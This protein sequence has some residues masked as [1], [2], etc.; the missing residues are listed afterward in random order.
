MSKSEWRLLIQHLRYVRDTAP[1]VY[2]RYVYDRT[3]M[4]TIV[5]YPDRMRQSTDA[6][7]ARGGTPSEEPF[8]VTLADRGS[9]H[10]PEGAP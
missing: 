2:N 7:G 5:D 8:P 9:A 6:E 4:D 10:K 3:I 1:D